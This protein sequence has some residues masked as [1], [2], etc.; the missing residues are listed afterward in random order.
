MTQIYILAVQNDTKIRD[1]APLIDHRRKEKKQQI[2][3]NRRD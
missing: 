3:G 1:R 2:Y